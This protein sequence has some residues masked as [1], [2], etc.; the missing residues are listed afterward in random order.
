MKRDMCGCGNIDNYKLV[1]KCLKGDR[2]CINV[3]ESSYASAAESVEVDTVKR[4]KKRR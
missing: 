2:D 1:R 4:E 3:H